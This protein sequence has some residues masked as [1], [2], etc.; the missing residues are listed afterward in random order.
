V[1]ETAFDAAVSTL[2]ARDNQRAKFYAEQFVNI[3]TVFEGKWQID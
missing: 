3:H 1:S 2:K